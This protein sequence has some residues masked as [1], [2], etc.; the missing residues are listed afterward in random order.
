MCCV[1]SWKVKI[2]KKEAETRRKVLGLSTEGRP[3]SP[4]VGAGHGRTWGDGSGCVG[5]HITQKS[6]DLGPVPPE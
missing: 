5:E 6:S 4:G 2:K 3:S 1:A